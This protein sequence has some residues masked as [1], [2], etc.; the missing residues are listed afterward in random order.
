MVSK[1][2]DEK[3]QDPTRSHFIQAM[4]ATNTRKHN[5]TQ[6]KDTKRKAL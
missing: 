5:E 4:Q 3:L 1:K 2:W 6:Q